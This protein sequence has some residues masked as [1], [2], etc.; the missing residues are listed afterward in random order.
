MT[1]AYFVVEYRRYAKTM[2]KPSKGEVLSERGTVKALGLTLQ[3]T[4]S[5]AREDRDGSSRYRAA[6]MPAMQVN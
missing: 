1:F 2:R 4:S 3:A 6:K 5:V